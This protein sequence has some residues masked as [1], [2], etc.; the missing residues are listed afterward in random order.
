MTTGEAALYLK[1]F[2]SSSGFSSQDLEHVGRHSLKTTFLS[3]VAK[4]N[5]LGVPDKLVLGHV[6]RENQSTVAYSRDE[7]SRIMVVLH[8]M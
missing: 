7:L 4:G 5:Y 6:S 8:V 1:E 2:L 3:W